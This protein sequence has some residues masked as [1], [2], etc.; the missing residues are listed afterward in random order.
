MDMSLFSCRTATKRMLGLALFG[1]AVSAEAGEIAAT[2]L[3]SYT[4]GAHNVL[5]ILGN[6][7]ST[8]G[9]STP[10]QQVYNAAKTVIPDLVSNTSRVSGKTIS[11]GQTINLGLMTYGGTST[12]SPYQFGNSAAA[13]QPAY[14]NIYGNPYYTEFDNPYAKTGSGSR[15]TITS[16]P[17][18]DDDPLGA[19][20]STL[21]GF[22]YQNV[23]SNSHP[24]CLPRSYIRGYPKANGGCANT[25]GSTSAICG[26]LDAD[27]NLAPLGGAGLGLL[28]VPIQA[29]GQTLTNS[30]TSTLSG[31]GSSGGRAIEGALLTACDYF[32]TKWVSGTTSYSKCYRGYPPTNA[33]ASQVPTNRFSGSSGDGQGVK[34]DT[35]NIPGAC[36]SS[37][38]LMTDGSQDTTADGLVYAMNLTDQTG[39][40]VERNPGTTTDPLFYGTARYPTDPVFV[41][42][43]NLYT[44]NQSSLI[45]TYTI[46]LGVSN[47]QENCSLSTQQL[48][49]NCQAFLLDQLQAMGF[50]KP[51]G[52]S[53]YP[54]YRSKDKSSLELALDSVFSE[55]LYTPKIG[56]DAP[57]S[58]AATNA[59]T[60]SSNPLLFQGKL[61]F[62]SPTGWYGVLTASTINTSTNPPQLLTSA[63]WTTDNTLNPQINQS[64]KRNLFTYDS[65]TGKGIPFSWDNGISNTQKN[66]LNNSQDLFN[67]LAGNVS[68]DGV[69]F[70]NRL[71]RLLGGIGNSDPVYAGAENYA[72]D[73]LPGAEGLNYG[74]FLSTK[75]ARSTMLYI[76]ANDGMLHG[77]SAGNGAEQFAYVPSAV[78][79]ANLATY[80][81]LPVGGSYYPHV[82]TVDGSPTVGDAYLNNANSIQGQ[83]P[84]GFKST[85][86]NTILLGT[87]GA[88]A[89]SV[90]ALDISDPAHFATGK[91]MW[92][93]GVSDHAYAPDSA[94][95]NAISND[96]GFTIAQPSIVRLNSGGWGAVVANGYNSTNGKAVLFIL[97]LND[98]TLVKTKT[99]KS[100][101]PFDTLTAGNNT[102]VLKNGLSTPL[103]VDVDG[104]RTADYIYA[105]DLLGNLWKFDIS[106]DDPANWGIAYSAGNGAPAPL[107]AAC[108]NAACVDT[109]RQPI[110]A[111]PTVGPAN[112]AGQHG[113]WM[114]YFG[115]GKYFEITDNIVTTSPLP[116]TQTFYGLYDNGSSVIGWRGDNLQVQTINQQSGNYRIGST[117]TVD[118]LGSTNPVK[119]AKRGWYLDLL[120]PGSGSLGERVTATPTVL[121]SGTLIFETLTPVSVSGPSCAA[122][123]DG[124]MMALDAVNGKS[125]AAPAWDSNKDGKIDSNDTV[126]GTPWIGVKSPSVF[127]KGVVTGTSGNNC[128]LGGGGQVYGAPC[129]VGSNVSGRT[130][131]TQLK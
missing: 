117:T 36:N 19:Q 99:G 63:V 20:S 61:D 28:Q 111:K 11:I 118:Y 6:S 90:F 116:Q 35:A 53:S 72:Y 102:T 115:T 62:N 76:G 123:G 91:V 4:P 46:G 44:G 64:L 74:A 14:S 104:N 68:K 38:V 94:T 30:L 112:A 106:S 82:Y 56:F 26:H 67:W 126:N 57:S 29:P 52:T 55:I 73:V 130:A 2:P 100:L 1:F 65:T 47:V 25:T 84:S 80:A 21:R 42:L 113:G 103:A 41:A 97:N 23:A 70:R 77:F 127:V 78:I 16:F 81:A 10:S 50:N 110:T 114:V 59:S 32:N 66:A 8:G 45:R 83:T 34:S 18:C 17:A 88:G 109:D 79:G 12:V 93:I 119:S 39:T 51:I 71:G 27:G 107:F 9:S 3:M 31:L 24:Y 13:N 54:A 58:A 48:T 7:Q 98:G 122:G 108:L 101:L 129:P 124:W 85:G 105:G 92:E 87:T 89:K 128:F 60:V 131:W 49:A 22:F 15:I 5:I 96:L 120:T 69:M 40:G 75:V 86:W 125:L 37:V 33:P 95:R 43:Y 121:S